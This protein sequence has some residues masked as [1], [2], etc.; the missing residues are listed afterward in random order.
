M[1]N[2]I[3]VLIIVLA[4]FAVLLLFALIASLS[5][6]RQRAL[7]RFEQWRSKED[8]LWRTNPL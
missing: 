5:Q 6:S 4:A 3:Q 7:V 2:D 8:L 1:T